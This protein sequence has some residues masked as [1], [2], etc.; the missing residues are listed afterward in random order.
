MPLACTHAAPSQRAFYRTQT[1]TLC[2]VGTARSSECVS[3]DV[4]DDLVDGIPVGAQVFLVGRPG[5]ALPPDRA[6]PV[7]CRCSCV[8]CVSA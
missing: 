5:I 6:A 8:C 7:L 1:L 4:T 3:V 2:A